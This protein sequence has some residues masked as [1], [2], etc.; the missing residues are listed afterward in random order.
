[1]AHPVEGRTAHPPGRSWRCWEATQLG[2]R[3]HHPPVGRG[4]EKVEIPYSDEVGTRVEPPAIQPS[5]ELAVVWSVAR[6][7]SGLGATTDLVWP[8]PS[9]PRKVR[10]ILRDEQEEQLWD[11]LRGEDSPWSPILPKP[12]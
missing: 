6:P 3:Q 2:R 4:V 7:S 8:Y 11:I 10:F 1:M 5:Q 9:D 12:G